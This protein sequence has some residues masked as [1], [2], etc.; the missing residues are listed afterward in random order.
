MI[1]ADIK[2]QIPKNSLPEKQKHFLAYIPWDNKYLSLIPSEYQRYFLDCLPLLGV[3]TTDVHI[4]VCFQYLDQ[5]IHS[6]E[7]AHRVKIDKDIVALGLIL[8][9]IGW[10]RLSDEEIAASLG[11]SGLKLNKAAAGP[12][13]RH[14]VEGEKIARQKLAAWGIT[15]AKINL[16]C[17]C[18]RWHDNLHNVSQNGKI[19]PEAELLADL[20]HLWSYTHLNFW[21][22]TV[23][24]GIPPADYAANLDTDLDNYF[25][26]PE[27]KVLA[28]RLLSDR[29]A[30]L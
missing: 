27:G 16:I 4:A 30:E 15:P 5:L 11:I 28:G 13:E 7:T 12:K 25:I 3:R 17:L 20:D 24:K 14:A 8:H 1:P 18:V 6:F 22:D 29:I 26:T 9:D 23:R 2:L 21:Q 19:P 10:S